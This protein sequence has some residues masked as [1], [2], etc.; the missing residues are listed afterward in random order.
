[1]KRVIFALTC[2]F[3]VI[4]CA[5]GLIMA[6]DIYKKGVDTLVN[7]LPRY[8]MGYWSKYSLCETDFHPEVDPSTIGYHYLHVIQLELLYRL[9]NLEI[10][11]EFAVKWKK[12]ATWWNII[13][14]YGVK[15]K[16]LKKMNRL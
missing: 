5:A 2:L 10:F 15:Y 11:S 3:G 9:T 8:D 4:L 12:Y 1:M 13:R 7:V 6:R 14:M 16:A